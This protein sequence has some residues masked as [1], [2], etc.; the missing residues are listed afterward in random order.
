MERTS[1]IP[2]PRESTVMN[3]IGIYGLYQSLT[4][5]SIDLLEEI[6]KSSPSKSFNPHVN[7]SIRPTDINRAVTHNAT[8]SKGITIIV[9]RRGFV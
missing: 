1:Y 9:L 2:V 5:N 3:V 4:N 6:E 8:T 7:E